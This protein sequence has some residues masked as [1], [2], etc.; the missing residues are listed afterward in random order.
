MGE[1]AA[2]AP[3]VS[4]LV[5]AY[6]HER[7]I[8][9]CLDSI[10]A[11]GYPNIEIVILN[12]GS[13]DATQ[14]TAEDWIR[15]KGHHVAGGVRLLHQ[16]NRGLP[17]TLNRLVSEAQGEFVTL[18]ASDD[19]LC[20]GSIRARVDYLRA[21]PNYL[22]VF[23]DAA[24]MDES[25]N[26]VADSVLRDRYHASLQA[27]RCDTTRALELILVW[28]VPGPVYLARRTVADQIG[29][30]DD[31]YCF[32]DRNYYL[33]LINADALGFIDRRVAL[34]RVLGQTSTSRFSQLPRDYDRV[35]EDILPH[36][37]GLKRLA[38]A[39]DV[40]YRRHC[41]QEHLT[42]ESRLRHRMTVRLR[43]RVINC[44]R[45]AAAFLLGI[46]GH[47]KGQPHGREEDAAIQRH[48]GSGRRAA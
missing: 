35:Q 11:D 47:A 25:D 19:G 31:R 20:P 32:E 4:V 26:L 24:E 33:R 42:F 23:G 43:R 48:P 29:P 34:Y 36:F 5:P 9:R 7:F 15:Q 38:L 44:N 45:V 40:A 3:L 18:L 14:Q 2:G 30:Y 46:Q 8:V 16:E 13:W 12:D 10:L 17:K 39:I 22:A 27:L 28:S 1:A 41:H 21:H 37:R 6:N